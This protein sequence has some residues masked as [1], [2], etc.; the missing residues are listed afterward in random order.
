MRGIEPPCAA[1]E[2][3]VLPLN[4]TR[5]EIFDFRFPIA[6]CN[7]NK[8]SVQI[9]CHAERC[10]VRC[11][12]R[13]LHAASSAEDS[14]RYSTDPQKSLPRNH[15]VGCAENSCA[16]SPV[17]SRSICQRPGDHA[18]CRFRSGTSIGSVRIG[19]LIVVAAIDANDII[20][21]PWIEILPCLGSG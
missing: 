21:A 7:R 13:I 11:P 9:G 5:E 6:D 3:A 1:W 15:V 16:L 20:V 4:Y 10:S 8:W 18:D 14:G 17:H 12:Q 2:A 19:Y